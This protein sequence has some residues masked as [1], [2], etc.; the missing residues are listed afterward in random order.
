M[1]LLIV[2]IAFISAPSGLAQESAQ[3][4]VPVVAIQYGPVHACKYKCICLGSDYGYFINWPD[5]GTHEIH[6]YEKK[7]ARIASLATMDDL[8]EWAGRIP[9]GV[10]VDW[11]RMCGSTCAGVAPEKLEQL[12]RV[13][14]E[15]KIHLTDLDDGNFPICTCESKDKKMFRDM[16]EARKWMTEHPGA[17]Y[18][19]S[20]K[21]I[22]PVH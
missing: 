2:L 8:L 10:N 22:K 6:V 1:Y 21:R 3:S 16:D 15:R 17:E 9:E 13:F 12:Q 5:N 11:L 4:T 7:P 19:R 14:V 20:G 18:F